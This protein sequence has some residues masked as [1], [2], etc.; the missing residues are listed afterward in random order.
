[1][2]F[3]D[4]IG[5]DKIKQRLVQLSKG[6]RLPHALM[7]CG[8]AGS[9]KLS[10]ALAFA[11]YLLCEGNKDGGEACGSCPQCAMLR[12]WEH[13][14][15]HFSFPVIRPA[16]TS[17]EHKMSSDDFIQEWREMLCKS[18]YITM[19]N[20]LT[21]MDAA[22]QQALMGVGESD[23]LI[24]K[25]SLKSSQGGYK[26]SVIWLPERMNGECANKLL[27]LL[28]EPPAQTLFL[29]IC[30]DPEQLLDTIRS[31]AQRIDV[32]RIDTSAV[33]EALQRLR[34]IEPAMAHRLARVAHGSW[35]KAIGELD[36][37]SEN[38][39][40]LDMFIMLMRLAY[41]RN[42]KD[43][44]KWSEAV[45][46][47]GRE[48]QRRMLVYFARMVRENFV[49]NFRVSELTYMTEEEETFAKKFSPFINERNIV[50]ISE[51]IHLSIRDIGQN[52]NAKMVFFDFALRTIM[53]LKQ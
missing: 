43:L 21:A 10:L 13:P 41:M 35:T 26:I 15:L 22:N 11:S 49:Y 53:L 46:S 44:K 23:V 24:R 27:K 29:M 14:D 39:Q 40:F 25:L 37:N 9:G 31:R 50:E 51:L 1:M 38:R 3:A 12:K 36:A 2:K 45:A 18:T 4:V 8:P 6:D 7:L 5:Q 20:W 17:S 34:G 28:E 52:A 30:E 19:D 16:G 47:Y 33:E 32:K 42:I 48:K